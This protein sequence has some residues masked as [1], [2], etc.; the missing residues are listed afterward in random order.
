MTS[1]QEAAAVAALTV[2][3]SSRTPQ[4]QAL[5]SLP[6]N[7]SATSAQRRK[8]GCDTISILRAALA[9]SQARCAAAEQRAAKLSTDLA[10]AHAVLSKVDAERCVVKREL[11]AT[12]QAIHS[13]VQASRSPPQQQQ[14]RPQQC[15]S[16]FVPSSAAAA[17]AAAATGFAR[18][19]HSAQKRAAALAP[20][21][22]QPIDNAGAVSREVEL[23]MP[24]SSTCTGGW[25]RGVVQSW[26]AERC[27]HR[28]HLRRPKSPSSS[29]SSSSSSN[30]SD[31]VIVDIS[32]LL[33]ATMKGTA[34]WATVEQNAERKRSRFAQ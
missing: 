8:K 20:L 24:A 11:N 33:A 32:D 5:R 14:Q 23:M 30:G 15:R 34:R 26:N 9:K 2:L 17:A 3:S 29:S 6:V 28:V 4:R 1:R 25:H 31:P 12:D 21:A 13:L 7:G 10:L 27:T 19:P 16:P 22:Q 18:S